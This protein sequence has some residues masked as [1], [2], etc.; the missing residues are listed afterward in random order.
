M[1]CICN[2]IEMTCAMPIELEEF[3]EFIV[4]L[5]CNAFSYYACTYRVVS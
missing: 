5:N 1:F 3:H 2:C 4:K